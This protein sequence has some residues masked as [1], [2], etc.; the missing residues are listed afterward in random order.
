[1][2]WGD[3]K[4][5][6]LKKIDP[7]ITSL[8]PTRNTKDYLNAMIPAANR[9]LYDL[10]TAGKFI[11]KEFYINIPEN[12]NTIEDADLTVQHINDD[13]VLGGLPAK[14]FY[15]ESTGPAK[16]DIYVGDNVVLTKEIERTSEFI[17]VKGI[18]PNNEEKDVK[19]AFTGLY[20]Y[21]FR[22]VALYNVNFQADDDV[23]EYAKKRRFDLR[24]LT[25]DFYMLVTHDVVLERDTNYVKFKDYEWEGDST[26]IL[27][28]LR[29]GNYIVH[30]YA[31]PREIT[32]ETADDYELG[33]DPEVA[34]LLPVYIASELYEDDDSN[35][36]YYFREQYMEA[37][38]KLIPTVPRGKASYIDNWGWD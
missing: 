21:Q 16:V 19:I 37:K 33:L 9:G 13:I 1:M 8:T 14:A 30:Y 32:I 6:A 36:A 2:K 3:I 7:A 5:N 35:M 22:N 17:K 34:A 10:A 24:E 4:L 28:G 12:P 26:L 29:Q 15:F 38:Q 18:I 27:D 31:Y 23:W 11:E 20:P 25:D